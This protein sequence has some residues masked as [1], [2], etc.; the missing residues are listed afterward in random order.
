MSLKV[1]DPESGTLYEVASMPVI[2][3][4]LSSDS[5]NAIANRTVYSALKDSVAFTGTMAQWE[6]LPLAD[7]AKYKT[8]YLTDDP[9]GGDMYVEDAV[10]E[11]STNPVTSGAVWAAIQEA[12][13]GGGMQKN[14]VFKVRIDSGSSS[15]GEC[16]IDISN[17]SDSDKVCITATYSG[18]GW[19]RNYTVGF[20]KSNW[21]SYTWI[22]TQ[23]NIG[24]E[25][26]CTD[27]K[28]YVKGHDGYMNDVIVT[29]P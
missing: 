13:R 10:T 11:D 7:K 20:M 18:S 24:P 2:D 17:L 26:K 29:L 1:R 21:S 4:V 16:V 23:T 12:I 25:F 19:C 9:V 27:G 15:D 22:Q 3:T 28:L 6:A 5:S 8:V 14:Y